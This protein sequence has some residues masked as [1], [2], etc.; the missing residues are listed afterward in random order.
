MSLE[1]SQEHILFLDYSLPVNE[2]GEGTIPASSFAVTKNAE[3]T[4]D[5]LIAA[6]SAIFGG[7]A[8][9]TVCALALV[10]THYGG[11]AFWAPTSFLSLGAASM[12][13]GIYLLYRDRAHFFADSYHQ[14]RV[15]H[16]GLTREEY[17]ELLESDKGMSYVYKVPNFVQDHL[18]SK[19]R[20]YADHLR[21]TGRDFV[22]KTLFYHNGKRIKDLNEIKQV[23]G[24]AFI[25]ANQSASV[26]ISWVLKSR[27]EN[28]DLNLYV[29]ARSS[30]TS[31]S[32]LRF[33]LV[34]DDNKG[35]LNVTALY[36][37]KDSTVDPPCLKK[38][39]AC[40]RIDLDSGDAVISW[41]SPQDED[42]PP[43]ED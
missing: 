8:I 7:A 4:A 18:N 19:A 5:I 30:K 10:G 27:Y 31:A 36:E 35:H 17:L 29:G 2:R 9:V 41:N 1:R 12:I 20:E 3:A 6:L 23:F 25:L 33:D 26:N 14:T 28:L 42:F 13:L 32:N 37:I 11:A 15:L 22:G 43:L 16:T 34:G 38:I 21:Q 39:K 24:D 40:M